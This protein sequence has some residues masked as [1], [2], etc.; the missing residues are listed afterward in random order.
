MTEAETLIDALETQIKTVT[1]VAPFKYTDFD[2]IGGKSIYPGLNFNLKSRNSFDPPSIR[3]SGMQMRWEIV[4]EVTVLYA[5][6]SGNKTAE[7]ARRH[8]D[9]A[10]EIF[11]NQMPTAERLN[12]LA[13]WVEPDNIRY[14][15]IELEGES[16]K[17]YVLGGMFDLTIQFTQDV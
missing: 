12:S 16:S 5:A 14:G 8:V 7:Q 10:V 3:P 15:I 6:M 4:Y 2:I 17:K 1:K 11:V 13:F 9:K